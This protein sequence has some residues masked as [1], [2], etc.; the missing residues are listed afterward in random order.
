M[1]R[2]VSKFFEGIGDI[3]ANRVKL[4]TA[5]SSF[6]GFIG[7]IDGHS[8]TQA[9]GDSTGITASKATARET[10]TNLAL[11]IIGV[12][13]AHAA[14]EGDEAL[15]TQVSYSKTDLLYGAA[16]TSRAHAE[17]L[18][19]A[20]QANAAIIA[21]EPD[22]PETAITDLEAAINAFKNKIVAPRQKITERSAAT[23]MLPDH[24]ANADEVLTEVID[25][26]MV[27]FEFTKPELHAQ[28]QNARKIVG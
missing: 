2:T 19:A 3:L 5:V 24:F 9:A 17:N 8:E 7:S 20:A 6:D 18:L 28:Y 27:V 10:M 11:P 14:I 22:L 13:K 21:E 25:N 26:L 1:Y 12:L 4:Q 23:A 15:R 16:E